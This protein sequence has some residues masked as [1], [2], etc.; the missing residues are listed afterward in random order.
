MTPN[1]QNSLEKE[2]FSELSSVHGL[3]NEG[4]IAGV[5]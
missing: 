4:G 3:P 2:K 1:S 5:C